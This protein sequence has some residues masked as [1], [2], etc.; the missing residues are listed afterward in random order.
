M[1]LTQGLAG[2]PLETAVDPS[3]RV[4][5]SPSELDERERSGLGDEPSLDGG[6]HGGPLAIE[7]REPRRVPA[8]SLHD[9]V[10]AKGPLVGEAEAEGGRARARVQP[11]ALPLHAAVP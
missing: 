2:P 8:P 9:H 7:H 4:S 10:L 3:E 5:T 11:V 1:R 6:A